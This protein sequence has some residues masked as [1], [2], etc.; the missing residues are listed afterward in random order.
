MRI[1]KKMG[2]PAPLEAILTKA[3]RHSNIDVDLELNILW[4]QW[5]ALVGPTISQNA[6]PAV[7]KEGMLIV[8]V[9]NAPWMQQLQFLKTEIMD[10]LNNAVGSETI[11]DIRFKIGPVAP[12]LRDCKPSSPELPL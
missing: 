3:L 6:T 1:R 11:K 12:Q 4:N 5:T 10:K 9:S 2:K 8:N 7:I